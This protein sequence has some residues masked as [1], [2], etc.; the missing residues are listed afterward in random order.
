MRCSRRRRQAAPCAQCR[1]S[2][3]V[4]PLGPVAEPARAKPSGMAGAR[5]RL[6][7]CGQHRTTAR[8]MTPRDRLPKRHP[9]HILCAAAE[10]AFA[11][12]LEGSDF[13]SQSGGRDDYGTD[14]QIEVAPDGNT[15]NV[16]V[17]VQLKG[18]DQDANKDGSVSIVVAQANLNYLLHQPYAIYVCYHR[19]TK[20]LLMRSAYS[21]VRQYERAGGE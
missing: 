18:T 13:F 9:S 8:A 3:R 11:Q 7:R 2:S 16:R 4:T 12:A 15:T 20:R 10:L 6:I 21:V 14:Y 17:H 19:P 1:W 5:S